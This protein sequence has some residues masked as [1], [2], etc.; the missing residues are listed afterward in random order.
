MT[1]KITFGINDEI[2]R[3]Y[4]DETNFCRLVTG[5]LLIRVL[6]TKIA[7]T[8]PIV[9]TQN[10]LFIRNLVIDEEIHLI[11]DCNQ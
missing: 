9:N 7:D 1:T 8:N 2:V 10:K 4:R 6:R 5:T 11:I 3:P